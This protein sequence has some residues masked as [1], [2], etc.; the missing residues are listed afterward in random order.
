M[1]TND[2]LVPIADEA[3]RIEEDSLHSAKGHFEAARH[4]SRAHMWLG[5]PTAIIAGVAGVSALQDQ[6]LVAGTLAIVAAA[7]A[8]VSTFL[9]P[10]K[11]AAAHH[12]AGTKFNSLRNRTR[13][14]REVELHSGAPIQDPA[15]HVKLL[16]RERDELNEASP[17][18]PRRAFERARRGIEAGEAQYEVDSK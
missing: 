15:E 18:I 10:S 1:S 8:S 12:F 11:R 7:L 6:T 16:G 5:L 9:N 4:W 17:Q 14:F 3:S 13:A 2:A